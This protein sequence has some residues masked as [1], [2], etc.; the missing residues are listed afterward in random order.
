MSDIE[1]LRHTASHILAQAVTKLY[2]GIKLGI[3][4]AIDNGFY[5][6]FEFPA[7]ISEDDL[8]KIEEEMKKIVKSNLSITK[9]TLTKEEALAKASTDNQIYKKELIT[10]LPDNE[11]ITYYTQ[12]DFEDLCKGPHLEST[13]RLQAFK[14]M[15][16]AGAYW[17]GDEKRPMLQ[18][19]YGT[20]FANKD[21]LK[22]HL[23][24]IE[25]AEKRDHRKLGKELDLFSIQEETGPGLIYWHPKGA[26]LRHI[27]ES[28]WKDE[29]FDNGYELLYTPHIGQSWLWE[30]SGH[31]GFY[32]ENM[33]SPMKIDEK[34]YYLKPMNC[35]FHIMVYKSQLRSYRDLPLRWAELGTVYR[36]ERSGV[37]H[38]TMRVRGFTQDDAHIFCT[39]EQMEKEIHEVIKFSNHILNTLGFKEIDY[40]VSTKP[41]KSVGDQSLWDTAIAGLKKAL[42]MENITDYKIDEGGGA[43]YGPKIDFKIKDALKREWQLSTIQFDFNLPERFDM[44]YIGHDGQKHRPYM[45]HRALL[46]SLERFFGILIEHYSGKFPFW[47]SPVQ[48]KIITINDSEPIT[49]FAN[50]IFAKL[51][52]LKFRGELDTRNEKLGFKI[53]D[54]QKQKIPFSFIIGEK[55]AE[56]KTVSSR[57]H[58]EKENITL[59]LDEIISLFHKLTDEK[60]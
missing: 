20:A 44:T 18:R 45:I 53:R 36:Y 19:I 16:I 5:Y 27:L 58:G 10:E 33:F 54:A 55:E 52:A 11:E 43:F 35:P 13:G 14:L 57:K 24:Q 60:K 48:F 37:L 28:Y 1:T 56:E 25:E 39:K 30:T 34:E 29:H 59:N 21:Q 6:D 4:P 2:P 17:R 15:K 32:A 9:H 46:G 31:L 12:G 49:S 3:G 51:K 47:L 8:P 7:P 40:Y 38:G 23:F 22:Q 26:R 41:T 42:E 50:E